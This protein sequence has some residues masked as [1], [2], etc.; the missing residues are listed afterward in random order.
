MKNK[1]RN[2]IIA[3]LMVLTVLVLIGI[4]SVIN[5]PSQYPTADSLIEPF[6]QKNGTKMKDYPDEI[7]K[8][9]ENN[10][11]TLDFV[12][13]YPL[14]KDKSPEGLSEN[15]IIDFSRVPYLSQFDL[16]WGYKE[17]AGS[18]M[19]IAGC[20]P[21]CLSMVSIYLLK[22]PAFD[23]VYIADF[24]EKENYATKNNGTKWL[25]MSEGAEKLG[26]ESE[27]LPLDKN[28]IENALKEGRPVICIMGAGDFTSSG[29]YIVLTDCSEDGFTVLDPY[30]KERS[31]RKWTY[32]RIEGQIRNIWAYSA[33]APGKAD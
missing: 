20:G 29:H 26:L 31:A 23:P 24:A 25:L 30:S 16:R 18:V 12:L 21:T 27:E 3:V 6:A 14:L 15:E 2:I 5:K 13:N 28:V 10:P 32:E 17:Y 11:E 33:G 4:D 7:R 1:K 9:L 8:M 19:G 22:D